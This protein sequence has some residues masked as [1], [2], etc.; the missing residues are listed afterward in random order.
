MIIYRQWDII[1]HTPCNSHFSN[2]YL[3][4]NLH[5]ISS[6]HHRLHL[7]PSSPQ[8][9]GRR[10][11]FV[12]LSL[13][14]SIPHTRDN[15]WPLRSRDWGWSRHDWAAAVDGKSITDLLRQWSARGKPWVSC[16]AN[17]LTT[18]ISWLICGGH[19]TRMAITPLQ[20]RFGQDKRPHAHPD[21]VMNRWTIT[22]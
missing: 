6:E 2:N 14:I 9:K 4:D 1:T 17:E 18:L 10:L 19:V 13:L 20:S 12:V 15:W 21:L 22:K 16:C 11:L 7:H 3:S 5:T 8:H